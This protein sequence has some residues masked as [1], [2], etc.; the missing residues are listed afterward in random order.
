MDRVN[1]VIEIAKQSHQVPAILSLLIGIFLLRKEAYLFSD[2]DCE[3]G[4]NL[5]VTL[6]DLLLTRPRE[7]R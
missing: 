1:H 3:L 6:I 5:P 2:E 4:D 7:R